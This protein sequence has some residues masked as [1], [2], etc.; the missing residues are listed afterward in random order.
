[1]LVL[2]IVII[3]F[4]I[5][6]LFYLASWAMPILAILTLVLNYRVYLDY[7]KFIQRVFQENWVFGIG[8]VLLS[9]TLMPFL[10]LYLFSKAI[11]TRKL[12]NKDVKDFW[13]KKKDGGD[14]YVEF[15]EV[16]DEPTIIELPKLDKKIKDRQGNDYDDYFK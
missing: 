11:L 6:G 15:E 5:K 16:N 14:E 13:D 8:L 1:M 7:G 9:I 4:L 3:Y 2:T 12:E 10:I